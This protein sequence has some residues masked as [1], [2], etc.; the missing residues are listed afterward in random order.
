LFSTLGNTPEFD[1]PG[2]FGFGILSEESILPL[3]NMN[4]SLP[5]EF[6]S[7]EKFDWEECFWRREE[8]CEKLISFCSEKRWESGM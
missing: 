6:K 4:E 5:W 3:R 2:G 7:F 8:F 1:S